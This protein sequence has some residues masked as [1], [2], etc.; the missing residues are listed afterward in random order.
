MKNFVYAKNI[1]MNLATTV[2]LTAIFSISVGTIMSKPVHAET[3]KGTDVF[4]VIM[5]I[6]EVD[7]SKGDIVAIVVVND[8]EAAKVKLFETQAAYVVPLN[9]STNI[10]NG[11]STSASSGGILEYVATF[12]DVVVNAGDEY[13]ACILTTKNL[14]LLCKTGY[15]SPASRPEFVDLS[16]DEVATSE[17][18]SSVDR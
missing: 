18:D 14:D 13:K 15:N 7:K 4:K 2:L 1:V 3:G 11:Q 16:L 5:T 6:F 17:G 12:P 9:T 8:G 10:F